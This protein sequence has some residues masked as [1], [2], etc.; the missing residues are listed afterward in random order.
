MTA[1]AT[2]L[3]ENC[4]KSVNNVLKFTRKLYELRSSITPSLSRDVEMAEEL[5]KSRVLDVKCK[6]RKRL[7]SINSTESEVILIKYGCYALRNL[8][9]SGLRRLHY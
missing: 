8:N 1:Q 9:L 2:H 7:Q 4:L 3:I 5:T 6:Q